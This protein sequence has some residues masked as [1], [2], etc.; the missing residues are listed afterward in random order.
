MLPQRRDRKWLA[1]IQQERHYESQMLD[2]TT[3]STWFALMQPR[4]RLIQRPP[5]KNTTP[6]VSVSYPRLQVCTIHPVSLVCI[7][8]VTIVIHIFF[9]ACST[10][11][12]FRSTGK[13]ILG[14]NLYVEP[15]IP[16]HPYFRM[17]S[18]PVPSYV[19]EDP[20]LQRF[21]RRR[22]DCPGLPENSGSGDLLNAC[23]RLASTVRQFLPF[24]G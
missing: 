12:M 4:I 20:N 11:P 6:L 1:R 24:L 15:H 8:Y 10:C 7:R 3:V 21:L 19:K 9:T 22:G 16:S 23:A 5:A 2:N 18:F 13:Q 17:D 14:P